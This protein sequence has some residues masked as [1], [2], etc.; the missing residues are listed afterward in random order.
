MAFVFVYTKPGEGIYDDS[1]YKGHVAKNC[2]WEHAMHMALSEDGVHYTPMRNNTGILFPECTFT[3]GKPEGTTKTLIDPWV[4]RMADGSFAVSAV[5]RNQNAPDP[6]SVGCLMLFTSSNLVRYQE[7]GFLKLAEG[8]IR[9]PRCA[10][11][12]ENQTYYLEWE[13]QDGLYCG[14][15][16]A[17]REVNQV[18]PCTCPRFA[19]ADG[20]GIE[21]AVP[22]NVIEVTEE[23]ARV[24]R[25]H[26]DVIE[27]VGAAPVEMHLDK[28]CDLSCVTW[29]KARM[30]YSDGSTH[31]K[32]VHWNEEDISGIDTAVPG[33]YCVRGEVQEKIWPFPMPLSPR[34]GMPARFQGG[35][36]DPAVLYYEGKYYLTSSGGQ[37]VILRTADRLEDVFLAEPIV[38]HHVADIPG[39]ERIGTW[40]AEMHIIQGVPYILTALCL[41]PVSTVKA[42]VLRCHGDPADPSAWEAPR[43]CVKPNGEVLTKDGI[44]LDMTY[45]C[46]HGVHYVMWS[47]RKFPTINGQLVAEPADIY[48]ATIDP[49]QPWQTTSEPVCVQRPV[50]GWDRYETEVDEGPYLIRHGEDMFI[51]VSG[52]STGMADLYDLGFLHAKSGSDLLDPSNWD[53]IPYPFLTKESVPNEYGPGHNSFVVDHE[54]GDD[55]M[56]YHAVPHDAEGKTLGRRPG[57]RRVHWAATGYP[58]LEMTAE[59]DLKPEYKAIV[60]KVTVE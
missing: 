4:F 12:K 25:N 19:A 40:A 35:M 46:D 23:E 6:L 50:Y 10:Y 20:F 42:H 44:S 45:F 14:F 30:L 55:M 34:P 8:E 37:D 47:D 48:I 22:G 26:F 51:T 5:R 15:T 16:Q 53:W 33:T 32:Q 49:E 43:L 39:V 3:E 60:M 41:G 28:G 21:N 7:K 27:N 59:R 56:V 24:I 1:N 31:D 57:V 58:Y 9:N 18:Q 52:S 29:P 17:F 11:E 38:V 54:T 36:S 2:D 13:T